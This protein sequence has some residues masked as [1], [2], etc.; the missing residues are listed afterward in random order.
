MTNSVARPNLL[1][2]ASK[3]AAGRR[4][5]QSSFEGGSGG[6]NSGMSGL[7]LPN[8][9]SS[10]EERETQADH[11]P[12]CA[13]PFC[14]HRDIQNGDT[15]K[16]EKRHSTERLGVFIG[17]D[18]HLFAYPDTSSVSQIPQIHVE[19]SSVPV[20]GTPI[21]PLD[22]SFRVY[23]PYDCHSDIPKEKGYNSTS[24]SRRLVSSKPKPSKTVGTQTIHFVADQFTR[25]DNQLREIRP[26]SSSSVHFHRD[27]VSDPYQYRQSTSSQAN[28]DI[29]VSQNILTEN[30]CIS[31]RFPLPLGTTERC[32]RLCNAGTVTSPAIT[33]ISAQAVA[34]TEFSVGSPDWFD[35]ENSATPQMVASGRSVSSWD[36]HE[37]RSSLPHHLYR[38]QP[39]RLG[40]SCGTGGTSV[41]WTMDRRPIPA[42]YQCA[43][44]ESNFSLS[45]TSDSQGKEFHLLVSTDNTTV[46]AYIRHQ[47]GTHSTV[48]PEEV[49]NILN[50]CLTHSIQ[51]LVKHIPGRFNT[52]G[53]RMSRIDKS[54]STEWSLNQEIAN[55]I[56]QIMDFPSID[57]FATRLNHRLPLY[58]SPIPDQNALSI[59]AISMDWNRIHA[60]A[61]PP[62]HLIQTVINKI[63]IS[64]YKIVLIAPLW[65]DRPWFP[66]LLGLLVSPPV[67]LPVMPNLLAQL[68]G[69]IGSKSRS[70]TTSRLGIVKQ[71]LRDKQFSS[72]VA[73]HV[74]KALRDSTVKVY[75]AKWQIF[76]DWANERKI[77]PIQATPQ[78]VAD[79][80]TFLFSVKKCQVSTIRGYRS[81]ISNT[82]KFRTGYD[83]G[84]HPVLSE[85]IK[86]FAKQRPVDRSLAPKWDLAFVLSHMCKA[87]FEPLDKASLFHLSVKTVFLVTLATA[88]RVSEVHAFSIDSDH[89]RFSNLD[90]SLIL[91]TQLGFLAKNQLPSRAPD[92][93]IIPRLSNFCRK[94]DNF[95][96]MLCPVRAV[97]IYL[98]KTK[99]LR[100]RRKRLFIPT[101]GD[102][103]LAK[104]TLSRVKYAIKNAYDTISKNPLSLFKPRA[105]ELRAISAS[106]AYMNY[107]PLEEILKSAVW[108]S[109]SLFASHYLRDFREQTENLR[110]MGPIIA[111]QKVVGGRAN[112]VSHQDK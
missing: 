68:K 82:L 99:S 85:L 74:S 104:P 96:R 40:S 95:N 19:R 87:P 49:W 61:F 94:S 44:D 27:G 106:W 76:R 57:L 89:L 21:R 54:I 65:P 22:K 13:Q 55:K 108:S 111:A 34:T 30:L 98:N 67:S 10:Q 24:L 50:L 100:K 75:D 53:D 62:F 35:N 79:F 17:S 78:I 48:L 23:T 60:Y 11:R 59:D 36:P 16:S 46:V 38:C 83:F 12:L 52:L 64:Q 20:Q 41:S 58:V 1:P 3:S 5:R 63:R 32:S 93:I 43:R 80:L 2:A 42:P 109:T 8:F 90:G 91:R 26:S 107:I 51:L 25:S 6:N 102:Q 33:N 28:E 45:N 18:G 7:L 47:G 86:S 84:S 37:D 29:G 9:P 103:D 73:E 72:E 56:F 101:Q 66:E 71:S 39:V 15:E 97:K 14:L 4:S 88:R 70:A 77:D 81:T 92:S 31:Q 112:P 110:A 69:R 105:H